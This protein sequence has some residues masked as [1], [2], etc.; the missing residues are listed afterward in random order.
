VI[1]LLVWI[2]GYFFEVGGDYQL[3]EFLKLKKKPTKYLESGL[4][5]YT[6]HPNYFGE[7]TMWWG[8]FIS[9]LAINKIVLIA[10]ISPVLIT[11]LLTRVSGIPLLE[12]RWSGDPEWEQYKKQT[13][14][15]I[16]WFKH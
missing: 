12:K 6:R 8:I 5:K 4:W 15:F 11:F 9:T 3:D 2:I 16:P 1:G 14:A 10:L 13:S 7:S